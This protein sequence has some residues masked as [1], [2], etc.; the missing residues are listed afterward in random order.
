MSRPTAAAPQAGRWADDDALWRSPSLDARRR[1]LHADC[2]AQLDDRGWA[3][4]DVIEPQRADDF[5]AARLATA[6]LRA[7][8]TPIRVFAGR[9][10]WRALGVDIERPPNRSGGVGDQPLHLDFVNARHPPDLVA[11]YCIRPDPHGGG[12]NLVAPANAVRSL[13]AAD[14]GVLRQRVF[15][16][17]EVRDLDHVGDDINPFAVDCPRERYPLRYTGKLLASTTDPIHQAALHRLSVVLDSATET[18][19]LHSGQL[20]VIDQRRALH[21]RLPLGSDQASVPNEARRLVMHTF[22]RATDV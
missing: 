15:R 4:I 5:T 7:L 13:S 22:V 3:V 12:A 9:P 1:D 8:G 18:I 16:D 14:R 21:G 20:L 6:V 11:L 17:G 2:V 19:M 10:L